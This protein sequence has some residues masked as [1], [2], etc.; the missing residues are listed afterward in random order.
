[1][2]WSPIGWWPEWLHRKSA[3]DSP[4][5]VC[6]RGVRASSTRP[7]ATL[8]ILELQ[9][10]SRQ[11]RKKRLMLLRRNNFLYSGKLSESATSCPTGNSAKY[12]FIPEA[13]IHPCP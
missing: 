11:K 2:H 1:M 8:S 3:S 6:F 4:F 5:H 9:T 12:P 7:C 13:S 10:V